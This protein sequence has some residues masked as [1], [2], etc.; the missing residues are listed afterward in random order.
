[1]E[2]GIKSA[3]QF[4]GGIFSYQ[5]DVMNYLEL[6]NSSESV[7]RVNTIANSNTYSCIRDAE[8]LHL[9]RLG[10]GIACGF[11]A[12]MLYRFEDGNK[13]ESAKYRKAIVHELRETESEFAGVARAAIW[14]T[15]KDLQEYLEWDEARIRKLSES[16][17]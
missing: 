11:F 16:T 4:K 3:K 10:I 14:V 1:M 6:D 17:T 5:R 15:C 8:D 2:G 12:D 9:E 13:E 7:E